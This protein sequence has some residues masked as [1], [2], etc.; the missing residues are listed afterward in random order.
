MLV[1]T[2]LAIFVLGMIYVSRESSILDNIDHSW[3]YYIFVNALEK[4]LLPQQD[5]TLL[6]TGAQKKTSIS[7]IKARSKKKENESRMAVVSNEDLDAC[8]KLQEK[9]SEPSAAISQ[10]SRSVYNMISIVKEVELQ[11]LQ[12]KKQSKDDPE[13]VQTRQTIELLYKETRKLKKEYKKVSDKERVLRKENNTLKEKFRRF[14]KAKEATDNMFKEKVKTLENMVEEKDTDVQWLW[15]ELQMLD[16]EYMKLKRKSDKWEASKKKLK[17]EIIGLKLL[18]KNNHWKP[19]IKL[20]SDAVDWKEKMD[21]ELS[22]F[23][24]A[25][26]PSHRWKDFLSLKQRFRGKIGGWTP[27]RMKKPGWYAHR[28]KKGVY[29][30]KKGL[31]KDARI[32]QRAE[33]SKANPSSKDARVAQR[34]ET[35]KSNPSKHGDQLGSQMNSKANA[36]VSALFPHRVDC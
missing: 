2:F 36:W 23:R 8:G 33:T 9:D 31:D 35:S 6:P 19:K 25:M 15:N 26:R 30:P 22:G 16:D 28:K 18:M 10:L 4:E 27:R 21:K 13:I 24:T 12:M 14:T 5:S 17:K 20:S 11:N 7:C 34:A 29:F 32:I 3:L 1:A